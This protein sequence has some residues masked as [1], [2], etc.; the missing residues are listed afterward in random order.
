M[1]TYDVHFNNSSDSNSKGF[2]QTAEECKA[3]I[4]QNNGTNNSYFTDYKGGT[5]SVVCNET[6]ETVHEEEVK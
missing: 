1:A 3:Y 6:G 4:E 5:V 2:K